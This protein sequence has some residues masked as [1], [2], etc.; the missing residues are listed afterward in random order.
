MNK[1]SMI[2]CISVLFVIVAFFVVSL[3]LASV[4][5]QDIV[6]EWQTWFGVIK[7]TVDN[8]VETI[9]SVE[10]VVET[11]KMFVA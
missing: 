4:H 7:D 9:P 2:A 3:I 10:D 6:T 5:G 11:A 1:K 8:V